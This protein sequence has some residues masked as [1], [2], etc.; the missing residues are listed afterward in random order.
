MFCFKTKKALAL[1]LCAI[2]L[3]ICFTGC[4]ANKSKQKTTTNNTSEKFTVPVS[5]TLAVRTVGKYHFF[6]KVSCHCPDMSFKVFCIF[7]LK[8]IIPTHIQAPLIPGRSAPSPELCRRLLFHSFLILY[9]S[10][11]SC[12]CFFDVFLMSF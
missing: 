8:F 7:S 1:C 9:H 6:T 2:T 3:S 5:A 11:H 12:L 10:Y 4:K